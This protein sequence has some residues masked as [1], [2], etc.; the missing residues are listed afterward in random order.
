MLDDRFQKRLTTLPTTDQTWAYYLKWSNNKLLNY[1]ALKKHIKITVINQ[2]R[3][4][5]SK[6][7]YH[8]RHM[9][10]KCCIH[11]CIFNSYITCLNPVYKQYTFVTKAG[12]YGGIFYLKGSPFFKILYST[13]KPVPIKNVENTLSS[14]YNVPHFSLLSNFMHSPVLDPLEAVQANI[15]V[16]APDS[17]F[18]GSSDNLHCIGNLKTN[19]KY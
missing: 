9:N 1:I 16:F 2:Q 3:C 17:L 14:K 15:C 10:K 13:R 4:S 18:D 5:T 19:K 11:V 8:A 12:K 7:G 6:E